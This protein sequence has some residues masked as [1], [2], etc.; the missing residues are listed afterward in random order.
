M[1]AASEQGVGSDQGNQSE[2]SEN[3][4]TTFGYDGRMRIGAEAA[5]ASIS[6]DFGQSM[7]T[8]AHIATLE[9]FAH[10]FLR[11]YGQPLGAES[12]PNPNET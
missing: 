1:E 10:Y 3:S 11:G 4:K 8:K 7:I 5:L 12:I 2:G 9:S 6:Y